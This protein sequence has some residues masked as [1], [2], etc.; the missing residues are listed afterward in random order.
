MLSVIRVRGLR[1]VV[2]DRMACPDPCRYSM[3]KNMSTSKLV[4]LYKHDVPF[5]NSF[6]DVILF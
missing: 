3:R 6:I 4:I 1:P 5:T 2:A